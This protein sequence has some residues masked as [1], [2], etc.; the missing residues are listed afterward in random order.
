MPL[1]DT[2]QYIKLAHETIT[3]HI[4]SC[5]QFCQ[6]VL[7]IICWEEFIWCRWVTYSRLTKQDTKFLKCVSAYKKIDRCT[8][9]H[10]LDKMFLCNQFLSSQVALSI[11]TCP[12]YERDGNI[13]LGKELSRDVLLL[14]L[15]FGLRTPNQGCGWSFLTLCCTIC[16]FSFLQRTHLWWYILRIFLAHYCILSFTSILVAI[17]VEYSIFQCGAILLFL[18]SL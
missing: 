14:N 3:Y 1:N 7:D 9:L 5:S 17:Q 2:L 16:Q 18:A 10:Q 4:K 15:F 13:G 12:F 11:G 6:F 8:R